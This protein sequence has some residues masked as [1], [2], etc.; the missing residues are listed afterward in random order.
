MTTEGMTPQNEGNVVESAN[1]GAQPQAPQ[2]DYDKLSSIL[3]GKIAVTEEKVL[4]GY[5]KEQGLSKEEMADAIKDFKEKRASQ[6]PDVNALNQ[7]ISDLDDMVAEAQSEALYSQAQYEAVIMAT[8]L[9]VES[10]TIPYLMKMADL[11]D[12][13]TD[14]QIDQD[15]LKESLNAVL[16]DIPQLKSV[17]EEK[18]TG[19]K[20]GADT[21][22][23][24]TTNE[25]LAKIFGVAK[26]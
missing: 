26:K 23:Q 18:S 2:I 25:E 8:E 24:T 20:I 10:K 16:E 22:N 11:S 17:A 3:D 19:F 15:K 1:E 13:V 6:V 14:G 21:S 7:Q 4:G 5:F 9:G 12:V